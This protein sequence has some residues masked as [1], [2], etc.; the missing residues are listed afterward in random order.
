ML[1]ALALSA[2]P[3]HGSVGPQRVLRPP[4]V[5]PADFY[6][7]KGFRE[8]R[9]I[10]NGYAVVVRHAAL[11]PRETP[12]TKLTCPS[13]YRMRSLATSTPRLG[14][15]VVAAD[16]D[17]YL[18]RRSVRMRLDAVK[19]SSKDAPS[20]GPNSQGLSSRAGPNSQGLSSRAGPNS[21]GL[22]SRGG[23]RGAMVGLCK[24]R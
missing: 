14:F 24:R 16:R 21:Q 22:S 18:R 15:L 13:G 9:P 20:A 1:A 6:P 3:A 7:G 11:G 5:L 2:A 19:I 10:P 17:Y 23:V 8:G 4:S 12:V